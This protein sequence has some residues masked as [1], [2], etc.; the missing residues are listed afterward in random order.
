MK[1]YLFFLCIAV[2]LELYG[3]ER[4]SHTNADY[5]KFVLAIRQKIF[6]LKDGLNTTDINGHVYLQP[7]DL[8]SCEKEQTLCGIF[9]EYE[10][11]VPRALHF[12]L[13]RWQFVN[14]SSIQNS[15]DE[16]L[17]R[18]ILKEFKAELHEKRPRVKGSLQSSCILG[19]MVD[20]YALRELDGMPLE[21]PQYKLHT[22][23]MEYKHAS[24]LWNALK[25]T[26]T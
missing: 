5:V 9:L 12:P 15:H 24:A 21:K 6:S 7:Y 26:T 1:K 3:Q 22:E 13:G 17:L 10:Y 25:Q 19:A 2:G 18:A 16:K 14:Q 23:Y 11:G 4:E 20:I 8:F